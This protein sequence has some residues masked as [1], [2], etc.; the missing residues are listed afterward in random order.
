MPISGAT[1]LAAVIG[2]PVEHSRSPAIHNA[3]A[4]A[5][6]V[7]LVYTAQPVQPGNGAAAASAMRTLGMR[8]LSVTMPHKVDVMSALDEITPVAQAL[9]AVNHITNTDGHLVGNNTDG[10]GFLL[11]LRHDAD[12]DVNGLTVGVFGA[13]GAAR[14]IIH[15]CAA[16]GADVVVV[17]RDHDRATTAAAVGNGNARVGQVDDFA[18]VD[19][20][21]NATPVGMAG[22]SSESSVPFDVGGLGLN[23]VVVDVVYNPLDTPLLL[24]AKE[25]GLVAIDGLSMLVGQAAAQFTAWTGVDAPLAAMRNAARS[26]MK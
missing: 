11:G 4:E 8:G 7:D 2:W 20:A 22:T 16:G 18:T 3:A 14:S 17:A 6:G 13:G 19:V 12:I 21:V 23:T 15:A 25:S 24:A 26:V 5:A 9:G 1:Q 10:S